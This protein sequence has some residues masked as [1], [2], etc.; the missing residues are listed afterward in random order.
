[1]A[2]RTNLLKKQFR[3]GLVSDL[4]WTMVSYLFVVNRFQALIWTPSWDVPAR[5]DRLTARPGRSCLPWTR[6]VWSWEALRNLKSLRS[7]PDRPTFRVDS[8]TGSRTL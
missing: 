5:S 2:S 1:M 8:S 4:D 6:L 7:S 3:F